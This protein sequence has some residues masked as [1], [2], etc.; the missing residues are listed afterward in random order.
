MSCEQVEEFDETT[1]A[2]DREI[3]E[4]K[5]RL[6]GQVT[7][8]GHSPTPSIDGSTE[9]PI[10]SQQSRRGKA[11]PVEMFS[12][13]NT[14]IRLDDWLPSL[15][16]AANWNNWTEEEQLLQFAG[17]LKG[18]ALVE[19]NLLTA[20]EIC[21]VERAA[22]S[23]R[24]RL[25]PCSKVMA[26]QDFRRTMQR[27]GESVSDF[28]CRLEKAYSIAYGTE[29]MSKETKDVMLYGQLQEGLRLSIVR[30]PSVS[31]ALSYKELCMA[32]KHEEKRLAEVK[33]RQDNEKSF[34]NTKYRS[35]RQVSGSGASRNSSVSSSQA[36]S[37]DVRRCYIC[38]KL[39][40][41]AKFCK[42]SNKEKEASGS[43]IKSDD[44]AKLPNSQYTGSKGTNKQVSTKPLSVTQ[45]EPSSI[46][47]SVDPVS[48]LYSSDSESSVD[49]VRVCDQ[50]SRPQYVNIEIQGV[51]TSGVI[52]T[53]ADITIMGGELFKKI[54]K[55][56]RLK[57][58]DFKQED[59]TP[60]T[61]DRKQFKLHGRMDLQVVFDG[62]MLVTPI[63]IKMD[64]H[65]QLLLSEGVCSQLGILE[66]HKNVWPGRELLSDS[67][68]S[69]GGA[70]VPLV[71]TF[72]VCLSELVTIPANK[73]TVVSVHVEMDK[74]ANPVSLYLEGNGAVCKNT[75]LIIDRALLQPSDDGKAC[76]KIHNVRG[77]TER[78]E[79]GALLG[80]AEETCVM[81][82]PENDCA[83]P[84]EVKQIRMESI[85]ENQSCRGRLMELI[86][87]PNFPEPEKTLLCEFLMDHNDVFA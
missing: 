6:A 63:Y 44:K 32:A 39:G 70:A 61:Y 64:A 58:R 48:L 8:G 86:A 78:I 72:H 17:H 9:L 13:E 33:K 23:M 21:T 87:V 35:D 31:G 50:G 79:E 42:A 69:S 74:A 75:G 26:G 28:I 3:A 20:E 40:H 82:P 14:G 34:T 80:D 10:A 27:D 15:R 68:T 22:K 43:L 84:G 25:D 2:K 56:A 19:W 53:G 11:P 41:V 67:P 57:K 16:R 71:R 38:N 66:Y 49:M 83:V 73:G 37:K 52:D 30:S 18:R 55:A 81:I 77:F 24:D 60:C 65:D 85:Q 29:K 46:R 54:A 45:S 36:V 12:G 51:P 62:N 59:R 76:L 4:L 7:E 5:L 1:A 47:V